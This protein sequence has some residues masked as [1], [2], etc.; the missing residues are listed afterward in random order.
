MASSDP[1]LEAWIGATDRAEETVRPEPFLRLAAA[2]GI[3]APPLEPHSPLPLLWH[4][5]LFPETVARADTGD[6]GHPTRGLFLPP[7]TLQRRMYAGGRLEQK[8]P[9]R[10]GMD[11][12]RS[13]TITRI[14]HKEARSGPLVIVTVRH[15][16]ADDART[17][18]VEEQDL[19]YTD[20][21]PAPRSAN[22]SS[23]PPD[24]PWSQRF[25]T[26]EVL[27]FRFSALTHN[28]HRIHYDRDYAQEREG[29]PDLVVHGPLTALLLADMART[30]SSEHLISFL[31]R[32]RAPLY[33]GDA[34][35]LRGHRQGDTVSLGAYGD[36]GTLAIEASASLA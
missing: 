12:T 20:S 31:F 35:N 24:A 16:I 4:W 2:L 22:G 11:L 27:L 17:L 9:L 14:D 32:A 23:K 15:H 3:E 19:V 34:I 28:S 5:L 6:D 18:L 13:R 1:T 25:D 30:R 33:V 36:D 29:Y 21:W 10:V 7:V 8:A 26:D